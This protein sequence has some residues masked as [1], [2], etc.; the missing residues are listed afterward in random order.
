LGWRPERAAI[1]AQVFR[2]TAGWPASVPQ[3]ILL[4][5]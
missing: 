3:R 4:G 2:V 5:E 1:S